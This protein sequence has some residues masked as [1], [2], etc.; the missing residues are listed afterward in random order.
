MLFILADDISFL[1]GKK[2]DADMLFTYHTHPIFLKDREKLL[3]LYFISPVSKSV[4]CYKQRILTSVQ[5]KNLSIVIYNLK[6]GQLRL[7]L[8]T[9]CTNYAIFS[10]LHLILH[11]MM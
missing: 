2:E 3:F 11:Q 10:C 1:D 4:R 7:E 6:N 9:H 8:P 5:N